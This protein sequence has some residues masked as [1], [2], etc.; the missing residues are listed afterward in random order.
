MLCFLLSIIS[1][2][3]SHIGTVNFRDVLLLKLALFITVIA[4][5]CLVIFDFYILG[6]IFFS[7]VQITYCVRYTSRE[8]KTTLRN[9]FVTFQFIVFLFVLIRLFI[10]K[11]SIL[12]PISLFYAICLLTSVTKAIKTWKN[13]LYPYPNNYM[14][15]IGMIL[16]LLC[17]ICVALSN[18]TEIL[19]L[20]GYFI[21]RIQGISASLIW[22]FYLPSQLLL[23]LSGSTKI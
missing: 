2:K 8:I 1:A 19:P 6:V 21:V 13:N 11:I 9:F 5:L 17:D 14:V 3:N 10:E 4:D 15:T 12:L 7:F 22:V 20:T 18:I 23:A 16:F